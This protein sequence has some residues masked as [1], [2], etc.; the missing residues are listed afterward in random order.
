MVSNLAKR[1]EL[2]LNKEKS[3]AKRKQKNKVK[4]MK[5]ESIE[6]RNIREQ[7]YKTKI[8]SIG[9]KL[10]KSTSAY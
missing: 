6:N 8:R 10:K 1:E 4:T 9:T 3:D 5:K 2:L 7:K